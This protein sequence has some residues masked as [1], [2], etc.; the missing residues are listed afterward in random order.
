MTTRRVVLIGAVL[1]FIVPV[2]ALT[3]LRFGLP[4]DFMAG[5]V[6]LTHVLWPS[7]GMLTVGWRSTVHG[8]VTTITAVAINCLIYGVIALLLRTGILAV[9]K[10]RP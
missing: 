2:I 8:I 10:A 7:Y 1:G 3:F 6:N 4:S 9:T 5:N